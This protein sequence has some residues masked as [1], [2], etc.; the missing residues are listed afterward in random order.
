MQRPNAA[1][2]CG[3]CG[4]VTYASGAPSTFRQAYCTTPATSGAADEMRCCNM[5]PNCADGSCGGSGPSGSDNPNGVVYSPPAASG[6]APPFVSSDCSATALLTCTRA[7]G[8]NDGYC[9]Y[10]EVNPDIPNN[11][12]YSD[13]IGVIACNDASNSSFPCKTGKF[14][15]KFN[16]GTS[17][18]DLE[19]TCAQA[20]QMAFSQKYCCDPK[21]AAPGPRP[22]P[23]P[24]V[25]VSCT[26]SNYGCKRAGASGTTMDCEIIADYDLANWACACAGT[27]PSAAAGCDY[28][29]P[30]T[31][32]NDPDVPV[33]LRGKFM[34]C[35]AGSG[36]YTHCCKLIEALPSGYGGGVPG[37]YS[38]RRLS[39]A[40][41]F[42]TS[43]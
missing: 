15:D 27:T 18:N 12:K 20:F 10:N 41:H 43:R 3:L 2:P 24:A 22:S 6:P 7:P 23:G 39:S 1:T 26:N 30:V 40:A 19:V 9:K 37:G 35:S 17:T 42:T 13:T 28:C 29:V 8:S 11:L 4:N 33:P 36:S 16:N 31:S 38:G 14:G 32:A 5:P 21:A 25:T 34:Q